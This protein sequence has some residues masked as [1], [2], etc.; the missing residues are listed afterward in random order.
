[1]RFALLIETEITKFPTAHVEATVLRCV[2]LSYS[3]RENGNSEAKV[4]NSK[5][6]NI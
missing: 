5:Y 4:L 6:Q 1:M 2:T 3:F